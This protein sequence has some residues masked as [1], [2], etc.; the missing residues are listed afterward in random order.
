M[1]KGNFTVVIALL[2]TACGNGSNNS[3]DSQ[4]P[5][6]AITTEPPVATEASVAPQEFQAN[7][8]SYMDNSDPYPF[9]AV[10]T[11]GMNG[12]EH[13]NLMACMGG[14]IGSEIEVQN[15]ESYGLYK[16]HNIPSEWEQT[17]RGVEIPLA[18]NFSIKM[19]NSSQS[20]TMGLRIFDTN[21][22]IVFQRQAGYW[23]RIYVS[24]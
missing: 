16:I 13:I 23:G 15:G 12:F 14:P 10:M 19:Q 3:N 9:T 22:D 21:G 7:E 1:I 8:Q 24:N 6:A 20:L 4:T 5:T 17:E 11:C 18:R 2:L